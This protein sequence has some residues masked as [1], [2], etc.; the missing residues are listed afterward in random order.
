MKSYPEPL[1]KVFT[2]YYSDYLP[3]YTILLPGLSPASRG[4][5]GPLLRQGAARGVQG[6]R[7]R[8]AQQEDPGGE[9]HLRQGQGSPPEDPP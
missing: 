5:P 1:G 2:L 9:G 8:G 3:Y 4:H 7:L 6:D